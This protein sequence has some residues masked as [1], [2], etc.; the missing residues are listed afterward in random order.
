MTNVAIEL[1]ASVLPVPLA[2]TEQIQDADDAREQN[3]TAEH[4]V[5]SGHDRVPSDSS[6]THARISNHDMRLWPTNCPKINA[7]AP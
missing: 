7:A 1:A 5:D 4:D 3:H 2:P 6:D